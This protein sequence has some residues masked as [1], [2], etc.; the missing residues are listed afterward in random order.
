MRMEKERNAKGT[1]GKIDGEKT[2]GRPRKTWE[3]AITDD[4]GKL[5]IT[6]WWRV[7]VDRDQGPTLGCSVTVV[8]V[9]AII[10]PTKNSAE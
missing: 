7:T 6:N 10:Y 9:Y 3:E 8:V 4:V 5:R 2:K 1:R